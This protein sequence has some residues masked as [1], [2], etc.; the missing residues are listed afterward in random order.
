[1]N[2]TFYP[3][4]IKVGGIFLCGFLAFLRGLAEDL[5]GLGRLLRGSD[6]LLRVSGTFLRGF[7][8]L[9]R[10]PLRFFPNKKARWSAGCWLLCF[11]RFFC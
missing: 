10:V 5:R 11:N 9:S 6:T 3:F 1:M 2:G 7:R 8:L 4:N